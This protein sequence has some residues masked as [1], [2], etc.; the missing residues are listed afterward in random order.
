M[1]YVYAKV[2]CVRVSD[3][4]TYKQIALDIFNGNAVSSFHYPFVYPFMIT[5]VKMYMIP[6]KKKI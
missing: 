5:K 1:I 3:E 2:P 6:K 4:Y